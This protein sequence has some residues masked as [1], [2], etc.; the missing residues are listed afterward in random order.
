MSLENLV[1]WFT[2]IPLGA[3]NHEA[4]KPKGLFCLAHSTVCFVCSLCML[5]ACFALRT[6]YS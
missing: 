6:H 4:K 5:S 3:A 2:T 1:F